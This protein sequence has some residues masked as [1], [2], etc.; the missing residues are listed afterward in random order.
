MATLASAVSIPLLPAFTSSI[1]LS[2]PFPPLRDQPG[3][4][5][6]GWRWRRCRQTAPVR[7]AAAAATP[8]ACCSRRHSP[9]RLAGH[10][11][12]PPLGPRR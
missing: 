4:A 11:T 10:A 5:E 8:A 3:G 7:A 6:K 2:P 9:Q 1:P 12:T